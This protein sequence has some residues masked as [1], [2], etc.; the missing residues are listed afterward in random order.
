MTQPRKTPPV[1]LSGLRRIGIDR[2]EHLVETG[3]AASLIAPGASVREFLDALPDF[4]AVRRL[5]QLVGAIV[6]ARAADLPVIFGMGAHVIKVG[7][8]PIIVDLMRRG[9]ITHVALNGAGAIHDYELSATGATSE[10][11]GANLTEGLFGMV[12]ETAEALAAAADAGA[13]GDVGLGRALGERIGDGACPHADFSILAGAFRHAR[14]GTVHVAIGTDTVHMHP[15]SDGAAIGAASHTDFRIFCQAVRDMH[16]DGGADGPGGVYVN[17]GS[18][19][20]LPE[21]FLKAVAVARNLGANLDGMTTANLDML[22]HYRPTRNVLTRPVA[23]GRG[24]QI[25]GHHELTLPLL[26]AAILEAMDRP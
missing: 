4:L 23:P 9:V 24:V 16:H 12:R 15:E 6:A 25:V 1:D 18:A 19:V 2:R 11:V 21:V 14:A 26:R 5:R 3:R 17:V 8:S 22:V 7:C 10:D 20:L 13:R